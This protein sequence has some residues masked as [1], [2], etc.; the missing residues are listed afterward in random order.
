MKL[1]T[2][3]GAQENSAI[4]PPDADPV[5][6]VVTLKREPHTSLRLAHRYWIDARLD[7]IQKLHCEPCDVTVVLEQASDV[8]HITPE[9]VVTARKDTSKLN[10]KQTESNGGT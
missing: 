5:I 10:G 1:T 9:I 2:T 6:W 3:Y 4:S 8:A 7:G